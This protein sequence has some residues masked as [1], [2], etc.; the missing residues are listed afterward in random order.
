MLFRSAQNYPPMSTA[1]EYPANAGCA[2][3]EHDLRHVFLIDD[4]LPTLHALTRMLRQLGYTV[5]P[6]ASIAEY[7][8]T[9]R[10]VV[11]AVSVVDMRLD[12]E[13]GLAVQTLLRDESCVMPVIFISGESST[14]ETVLAMKAGAHEFLAKPVSAKTLSA[15]IDSGLTRHAALRAQRDARRLAAQRLKSLSPRER[16]VFHLLARGS[17]NAQIVAALDIS[18][19]TAK[20]YKSE[21]MRK[22]EL[23]SLVAL[24][25]FSDSLGDGGAQA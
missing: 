10:D 13:S 23:D 15:A 21:V 14:R 7:R 2:T 19:P 18:L 4:D 11:P 6:F 22:L 17:N 24:L 8:E 16:E 5:H 20:Q 9:S 1:T 3:T 12:G 25:E